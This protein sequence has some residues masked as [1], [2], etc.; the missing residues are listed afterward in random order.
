MENETTNSNKI[1]YPDRINLT[2]DQSKRVEAWQSQ[3]A[4]AFEGAVKLNRSDLVNFALDQLDGELGRSLLLKLFND[5]FDEL[6]FFAWAKPRII[7]AKKRGEALTV[8]SLRQRILSQVAQDVL[9][10]KKSASRKKASRL[11]T[12]D[13]S[14]ADF[15][16]LHPL[17]NET[18][19][20]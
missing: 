15:S 1:A 8:E 12:E 16:T 3:I 4:K 6:K 14:N 18:S 13:E 7:E 9:P 19:N 2:V 17:E 20:E 11:S 5:Q 10:V